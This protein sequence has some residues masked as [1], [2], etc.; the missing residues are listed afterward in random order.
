MPAYNFSS[1]MTEAFIHRYPVML[2]HRGFHTHVKISVEPEVIQLQSQDCSGSPGKHQAGKWQGTD[3]LT[4]L[5]KPNLTVIT[6]RS[7]TI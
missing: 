6:T 1:N 2:Y 5:R 3:S 4:A 7:T